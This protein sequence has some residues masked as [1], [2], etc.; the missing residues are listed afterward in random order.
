MPEA[1]LDLLLSAVAEASDVAL[2]FSGPDAQRWDKADGAGPVT[3]ADLAVNAALEARLR[4][5]RS[6]YGWL[7]EESEDGAARQAAERVF[8][9]DPI[10]GT[11]SFIEGSGTWAISAAIVEAGVPVAGVVALP[12]RGMVF[13]AAR[14]AGA[15]EN[16]AAIRPSGRAELDGAEMLVPRPAMKPEYWPGGMPDVNRHHRPSLA[17][18]LCLAAKGRF[19][20]MLTL[21]D[22]WEWDIAAGALIAAEAGAVVS[23]RNGAALR[24]NS[25][26]A[27]TPGVL[28]A[29]GALH[30]QL[31]ARRTSPA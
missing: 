29:N 7:S 14:G 28:V 17:Y 30:R 27:K 15:F 18:R 6:D 22:A 16:G 21:R 13:S 19:D 1:D 12:A 26:G 11:R 9:I 8:V 2:R 10:D 5:A 31:V 24:F 4:G 3:E 23:D 20:A 25:P